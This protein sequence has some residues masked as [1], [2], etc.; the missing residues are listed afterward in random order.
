[1]S[2]MLLMEGG[3]TE[4]EKAA[5]AI[6]CYAAMRAVHTVRTWGCVRNS[7]ALVR[8]HVK[9]GLKGSTLVRRS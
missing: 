7:A 1:M 2:S 3:L 4:G 9:E 8:L 5:I 6:G